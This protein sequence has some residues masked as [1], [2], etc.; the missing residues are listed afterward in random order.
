MLMS[1]LP[2]LV[3]TIS[4]PC[5][6]KVSQSSWLSSFI[7]ADGELGRSPLPLDSLLSKLL[8]WFAVPRTEYGDGVPCVGLNDFGPG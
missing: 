8:A 2:A 3:I 1:Y 6:L 4:V 5:L 7:L